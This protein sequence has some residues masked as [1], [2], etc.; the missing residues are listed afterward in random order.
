MS[1]PSRPAP[2]RFVSPIHK[3]SRQIGEF[4]KDASRAEGVEPAEGHLLSYVTLYGPCTA[5][6]LAGVFGH[7]PSTLTGML[8]R[9]VERG[10]AVREPNTVDR[11]SFLIRTTP[12][13]S[14]VATRLRALLEDLEERVAGAVDARDAEGFEAVMRAIGDLT[15]VELRAEET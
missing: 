4:L 11:R 1:D 5:T 6:E 13:G 9:L 14:A 3:A 12:R 15:K 7:K 2:L 8:D 10:L